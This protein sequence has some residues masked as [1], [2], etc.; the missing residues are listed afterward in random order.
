M[1]T[2]VQYLPSISV[3]LVPIHSTNNE[4]DLN[5]IPGKF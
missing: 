3:A 4:L 5:S 1:G 2:R